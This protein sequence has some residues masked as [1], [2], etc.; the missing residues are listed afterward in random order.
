MDSRWVKDDKHMV[1]MDKLL[2]VIR[3]DE[4]LG[5][6]STEYFCI[7]LQYKNLNKK[8]NYLNRSARDYMYEKISWALGLG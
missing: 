1:N 5:T 2:T 8:I 3:V 4:K 7:E 6:P